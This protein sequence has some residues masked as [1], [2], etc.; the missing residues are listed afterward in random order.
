M[1]TIRFSGLRK[2]KAVRFPIMTMRL[3]ASKKR[4]RRRMRQPGL[5][6]SDVGAGFAA[7]TGHPR[8]SKQHHRQ[9]PQRSGHHSMKKLQLVIAPSPR[10]LTAHCDGFFLD[11][12]P[13]VTAADRAGL[14]R[15]LRYGARP[16]F[17]HDRLELLANGNVSDRLP[18]PFYTG[19]THVV[20]PPVD[21]LRRLA[22]LIPPPRF[23]TIRYHSLFAPNAKLRPLA[24]ALAPNHVIDIA[25]DETKPTG[26]DCT[27]QTKDAADNPDAPYHDEHAYCGRNSCAASSPSTCCAAPAVPMPTAKSS[28]FCPA[29]KPQ[30]HS[31]TSYAQSAS[32]PCRRLGPKLPAATN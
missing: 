17:A 18:K 26:H 2:S 3:M 24:C 4:R 27:D 1:C 5:I 7:A 23:H 12:K 16:A 10:K 21:F 28:V 11:C 29:L 9:R 31:I 20:L 6:H 19:Q 8:S 14:E 15:L 25:V 22:A 13:S 30:M 32:R